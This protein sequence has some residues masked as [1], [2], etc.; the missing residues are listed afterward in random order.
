[1]ENLYGYY[2]HYNIYTNEWN[3][4][5]REESVKYL[6]G[7]KMDSL[8]KDKDIKVLIERVKKLK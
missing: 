5:T 1:M 2:F 6:N 4:L 8:I 3:A 7:I